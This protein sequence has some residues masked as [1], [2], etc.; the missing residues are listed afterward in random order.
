[1]YSG[2]VIKGSHI[3]PLEAKR[4][5]RK[6]FN[7]CCIVVKNLDGIIKKEWPNHFMNRFSCPFLNVNSKIIYLL[8]TISIHIFN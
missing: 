5:E 3:K 8:W 7:W 6:Y 2:H 4:K 1:M